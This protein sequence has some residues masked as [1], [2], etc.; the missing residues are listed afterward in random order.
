M[1]DE[2]KKLKEDR[3]GCF[4]PE[5]I[6]QTTIQAEKYQEEHN[7]LAELKRQELEYRE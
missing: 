1:Q 5:G 7:G 4:L 2:E 3:Q 6:V